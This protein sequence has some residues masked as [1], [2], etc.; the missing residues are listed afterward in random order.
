MKLTDRVT[1]TRRQPMY[2][3]Q[4][5][6]DGEM[7]RLKLRAK[8]KTDAINEARGLSVTIAALAARYLAREEAFSGRLA[9]GRSSSIGNG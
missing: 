7:R 6:V 5:R 2:E 3:L 4:K 8:I 1:P 9:S